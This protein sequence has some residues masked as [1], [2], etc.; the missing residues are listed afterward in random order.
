MFYGLVLVYPPALNLVVAERV[1][2]FGS[3]GSS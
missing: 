1:W 3:K 2:R